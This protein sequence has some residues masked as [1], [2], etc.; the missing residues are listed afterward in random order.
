MALTKNQLYWKSHLEALQSFDGTAAEYARL[1]DL[2]VKKLYV[3]KS[4]WRDHGGEVEQAASGFVRVTTQTAQAQYS[5]GVQVM[6]PNGVRL[7]LP[8]VTAPG[9]LERLARL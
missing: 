1:H 5:P 6:L 4:W 7:G 2:E 3:Y 9:L 8:D